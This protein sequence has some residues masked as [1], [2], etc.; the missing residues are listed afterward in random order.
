LFG[1]FS[2]SAKDN[3]GLFAGLN[4]RRPALAIAG[5]IP[6]CLIV[7]RALHADMGQ[8]VKLFLAKLV[9]A[10]AEKVFNARWA[11][12][13]DFVHEREFIRFRYGRKNYFQF[14]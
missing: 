7:F 6:D 12:D 10:T 5:A 13:G 11:A 3:H 14:F 8:N 9:N 2:H 1:A 4:A